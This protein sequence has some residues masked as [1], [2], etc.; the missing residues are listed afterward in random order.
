[1]LSM[2]GLGSG[3]RASPFGKFPQ[4]GACA[5]SV[6][7]AKKLLA[8]RRWRGQI[9]PLGCPVQF[10]KFDPGGRKENFGL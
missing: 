2:P 1:M 9:Y 7:C 8:L 10:V 6:F 4:A 5:P 3:F